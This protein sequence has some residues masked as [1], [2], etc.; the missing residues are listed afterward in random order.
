M[1][2]CG[3]GNRFGHQ[4]CLLN[5]ELRTV[6]Q[7][8]QLQ[9]SSETLMYV[10]ILQGRNLCAIPYI[11]LQNSFLTEHHVRLVS[12]KK[13][14]KNINQLWDIDFFSLFLL[15]SYFEMLKSEVP[16]CYC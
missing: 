1:V 5:T 16:G 2:F 11:H 7:I 8:S 3:G 14:K 4:N 6:K 12:K 10:V 9:A 13:E 15:V